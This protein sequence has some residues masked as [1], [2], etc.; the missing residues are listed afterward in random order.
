M[1]TLTEYQRAYLRATPAAAKIWEAVERADGEPVSR[2]ELAS[3]TRLS[4]RTVRDIVSE[5]NVHGFPIVA[6]EHA[7]G[8]YKLGT[9][10]ECRE[11]AAVLR[12]KAATL[13]ERAHGLTPRARQEAMF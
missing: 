12:A 5:M 3:R 7:P 11:A 13:Y 2:A 10:D 8:G 4:D 6:V 1:N 9:E